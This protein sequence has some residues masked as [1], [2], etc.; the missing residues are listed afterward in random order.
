MLSGRCELQIHQTQPEVAGHRLNP[1]R[2]SVDKF[3]FA[4]LLFHGIRDLSGRS[5]QALRAFFGLFQRKKKWA[6]AHFLRIRPML[7]KNL[8]AW[9]IFSRNLARTLRKLLAGDL[10]ISR[11]IE[12][13]EFAYPIGDLYLDL[14]A[15]FPIQQ[16]LADRRAD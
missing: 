3:A 5:T 14:V 6:G 7:K 4:H 12:N 16:S 11:Q 10:V 8:L 15:N 2:H 1:L 9:A 13:F